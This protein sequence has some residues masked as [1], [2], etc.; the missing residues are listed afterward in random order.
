MYDMKSFSYVVISIGGNDASSSTDVELLKET[1]DQLIS[2]IKTA[3]PNCKLN[4]CY[5]TPRGDV[6]VTDYS[7]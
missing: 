6:D 2:V 1:Y 4:L 7:A 5:I 3:N